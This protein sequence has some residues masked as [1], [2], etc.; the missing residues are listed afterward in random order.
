M[1]AYKP[2]R[3]QPQLD[4]D[5]FKLL[6]DELF[7]GRLSGTDKVQAKLRL[8]RHMR[9]NFDTREGCE[10]CHEYFI[11]MGRR[12]GLR[13]GAEGARR[14]MGASA[15]DGAIVNKEAEARKAFDGLFK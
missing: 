1:S 5:A 8:D 12:E 11:D 10:G 3:Q 13:E 15:G 7:S 9:P 2:S 6:A 4:H 14:A